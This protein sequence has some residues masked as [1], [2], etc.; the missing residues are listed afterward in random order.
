MYDRK[1]LCRKIIELYPDIGA[2]GIDV[3]V[4]FDKKKNVWIVDLKKDEH[5]LKHH[6]EIPDADDCME[7]RQCTS[8]GLEIAQLRK[9]IE[10]EQ[11]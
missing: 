6:L 9:N 4:E 3:N 5:E 10:G 1:E 2:C 7:G 11:F 8:L